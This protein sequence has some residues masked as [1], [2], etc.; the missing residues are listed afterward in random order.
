MMHAVLMDLM[1]PT[2][3]TWLMM[4]AGA[5][6]CAIVLSD[7]GNGCRPQGTDIGEVR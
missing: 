6:R 7:L 4:L 2:L 1:N 5:V 3:M